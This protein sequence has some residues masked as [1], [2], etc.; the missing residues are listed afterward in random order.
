MKVD[1]MTGPV[2]VGSF[3]TIEPLATVW[4]E[5]ENYVDP[6]LVRLRGSV[7]VMSNLTA[8]AGA[9]SIRAYAILWHAPTATSLDWAQEDVSFSSDRILWVGSYASRSLVT[10][11]TAVGYAVTPD[12]GM[13]R[14]VDS[15]AMRK[16]GDDERLWLTVWN[17]SSSS[18]TVSFGWVLRA[19]LKE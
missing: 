7:E 12:L 15:K 3:M 5:I 16:L 10:I 9:K 14:E 8:T 2:T 19:L 17:S 1:A 18:D 6:T 4:A 13:T 11:A